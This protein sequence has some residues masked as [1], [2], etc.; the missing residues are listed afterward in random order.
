M[1]RPIRAL[2]ALLIAVLMVGCGSSVEPGPVD[3]AELSARVQEALDA[4]TSYSMTMSTLSQTEASAVRVNLDRRDPD[5]V[6]VHVLSESAGGVVEMI[7]IGQD[8]YTLAPAASSWVHTTDGADYT[9]FPLAQ[10]ISEAA[11]AEAIGPETISGIETTRYALYDAGGNSIEMYVDAADR[12]LLLVG[13]GVEGSAM[14]IAFG[15]FGAEFDIAA[16]KAN[17]V[18]PG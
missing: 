18:V 11:S 1:P 9:E 3:P 7:Q 8:V 5:L 10:A 15:N 17:Q 16:P 2:F 14:E 4:E 6:K 13:T 12:L